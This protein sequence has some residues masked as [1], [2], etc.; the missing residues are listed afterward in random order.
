MVEVVTSIQTVVLK[1]SN[2]TIDQENKTMMNEIHT[3]SGDNDATLSQ[4]VEQSDVNKQDS[5]CRRLSWMDLKVKSSPLVIC[6]N[7]PVND[8]TID[9]KFPVRSQSAVDPFSVC[10]SDRSLGHDT[11]QSVTGDSNTTNSPS[12]ESIIKRKS[13]LSTQSRQSS[14][15]TGASRLRN[16]AVT[17]PLSTIQDNDEIDDIIT[18]KKKTHVICWLK[19]LTI[20]TLLAATVIAAVLSYVIILNSE[21]Q[22]FE[23]QYNAAVEKLKETIQHDFRIKLDAAEAFSNMY[24]SRYGPQDTWPNVTMPNFAEQAKGLLGVSEG[25]AL[26]FN[27]IITNET[28]AGWEAH[29]LESAHLLG[30]NNHLERFCFND[31]CNR[32]VADGIY[33]KV[34]GEVV[35][36]PGYSPGSLYPYHLVPVWQIY[37]SDDNWRAVMFNLHS[38]LYRQRALDDMIQYQVPT[39]TGLLHLVQHD[40]MD[41]SSILFYPVFNNFD[42]YFRSLVGSISIVFT[43][44]DIL[45]S[46]LPDYIKGLI[47]VLEKSVTNIENQQTYTYSVSGNV[48]TLLGDGDYHD[49]TFDNQKTEVFTNVAAEA[50]NLGIVH[51]LVTY[52]LRIYPSKE[53][54]SQ[55][56]TQKPLAMTLVVVFIFIL[57]SGIFLLYDYLVG[58]RQNSL[59]KF[60]KQSGRIVNSFFPSSVRDR[61]FNVE[62]ETLT[63][64]TLCDVEGASDNLE[65]TTTTNNQKRHSKLMMRKSIQSFLKGS[66]LKNESIERIDDENDQHEYIQNSPPI[67]DLFHNTTIMFADIVSFTEW[68][69]NHTPEDVFYLLETLFLEFDKAA[70]RRG[71]FKLGTIGK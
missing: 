41:P 68:S 71:V 30:N 9:C 60:A 13:L 34:D 24:T 45:R 56:V 64:Q 53:F 23:K 28:R 58:S 25:I 2:D 4:S 70:K 55:Y 22:V 31:V 46:S 11:L 5:R 3:T 8:N 26:S 39:I 52:K 6:E 12:R 40:V 20:I 54:K 21:V 63:G 33:R 43:W 66:F 65:D 62:Q 38:E 32:I 51:N 59:M 10:S 15:D 37:P 69:S 49:T 57:T 67:A 35:D 1:D 48:V 19:S 47:V 18:E 44:A 16:S 14:G 27:P 7:M 50:E 36:D 29:A 42:P 61:V 17:N